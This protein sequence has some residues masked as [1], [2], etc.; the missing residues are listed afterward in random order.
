[1]F[2]FKIVIVFAHRGG[3]RGG[4]DAEA[5]PHGHGPPPPMPPMNYGPPPPLP[6]PGPPSQPPPPPAPP[7]PPANPDCNMKELNKMF[8]MTASDIDK[9][10]RVIFPVTFT[11]FQLMYW[12]IYQHLSDE[13]L[14]DLVYLQTE[15]SK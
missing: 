2:V 12:I 14:E 1:M 5:P 9:Y 15:G 4:Y 11:C 7:A 6:P 3:S 13:V 8:G 10:S